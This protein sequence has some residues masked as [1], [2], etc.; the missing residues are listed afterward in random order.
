VIY[1]MHESTINIGTV[2]NAVRVLTTAVL[3]VKLPI[4]AF[5]RAVCVD[6]RWP[7]RSACLI[8]KLGDPWLP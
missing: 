5:K 3:T 8:N 4:S 2:W 1:P 6:N 7:V